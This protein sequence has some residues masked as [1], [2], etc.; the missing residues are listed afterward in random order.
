MSSN[1]SGYA[2]TWP[3]RLERDCKPGG[4]WREKI[5]GLLE[6]LVD[7]CW[8]LSLILHLILQN[9]S[10]NSRFLIVIPKGTRYQIKWKGYRLQWNWLIY[11]IY[12]YTYIYIY[13]HYIYS[14]IYIY[15]YIYI[16]THYIYIYINRYGTI[17]GDLSSCD[18]EFHQGIHLARW[19]QIHWPVPAQQ[20][21]QFFD[22]G[23]RW[24]DMSWNS[25]NP[26]GIC[27]NFGICLGYV[28][29]WLWVLVWSWSVGGSNVVFCLNSSCRASRYPL[30][31]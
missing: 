1:G 9:P 18:G 22:G 7:Q 17:S 26:L 12:I 16:Y 20:E 4:S 28:W 31:I 6:T 14:H 11:I 2:F 27:L 19:L 23:P 25:T 15:I 10:R 24:K 13:T 8:P 29:D 3:K 5:Q 21:L 30:L